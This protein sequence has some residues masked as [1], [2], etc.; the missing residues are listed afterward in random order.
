MQVY[1][2]FRFELSEITRAVASIHD[3]FPTLFD[4]KVEH[5]QLAYSRVDERSE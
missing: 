3:L 5:G 4:Y 1:L 2:P